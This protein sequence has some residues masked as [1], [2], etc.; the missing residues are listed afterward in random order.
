M[1][2][3]S[4][5]GVRTDTRIY[6]GITMADDHSS[7]TT[8]KSTVAGS[9]QVQATDS[10]KRKLDEDTSDSSRPSKR[11]KHAETKRDTSQFTYIEMSYERPVEPQYGP[12]ESPMTERVPVRVAIPFSAYS[13]PYSPM[14]PPSLA[15]D[16]EQLSTMFVVIKQSLVDA[17]SIYGVYKTFFHAEQALWN[18]YRDET[19]IMW[20]AQV[21]VV[22][23]YANFAPTRYRI[24]ST[25][26]N[27]R[28]NVDYSN[29]SNDDDDDDDLCP[30]ESKNSSTNATTSTS[31]TTATTTTA[32]STPT[33]VPTVVSKDSKSTK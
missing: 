19:G 33:T 7:T 25:Y 26:L 8:G 17:P 3:I 23:Y 2:I 24:E 10:R 13:G 16:N 31:S 29:L 21:S 14:M 28:L 6:S 32:A 18:I 22:D 1:Y 30:T 11:G 12:D 9:G 5:V 15:E 20:P 27:Y 4:V